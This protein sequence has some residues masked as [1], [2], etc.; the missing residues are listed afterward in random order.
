MLFVYI[1]KKHKPKTSKNLIP[2]TA[3]RRE[4]Y[5]A[6][7]NFVGRKHMPIV[8][9]F[10]VLKV[11]SMSVLNLTVMNKVFEMVFVEQ[12]TVLAGVPYVMEHIANRSR[13][14]V[15][16][17]SDYRRAEQSGLDTRVSTVQAM[18]TEVVRERWEQTESASLTTRVYHRTK[19]VELDK[20]K[21]EMV[22]KISRVQDQLAQLSQAEVTVISIPPLRHHAYH[23]YPRH[24]HYHHH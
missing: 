21:A 15:A 8:I 11:A 4:R 1:L 24:H 9:A 3:Q 16:R 2:D 12:L 13:D 6:N 19:M 23:R 5:K 7:P 20:I 22:R 17:I 18:C 10:I 14:E